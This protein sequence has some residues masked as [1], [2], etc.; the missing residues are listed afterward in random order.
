MLSRSLFACGRNDQNQYGISEVLNAIPPHQLL[1]D[2]DDLP[3]KIA[4][5]VSVRASD[6][7]SVVLTIHGDIYLCGRHTSHLGAYYSKPVTKWIRSEYM[8]SVVA[9]DCCASHSLFIIGTYDNNKAYSQQLQ[10]LGSNTYNEC[11]IE[12]SSALLQQMQKQQ[13]QQARQLA[14]QDYVKFPTTIQ[15]FNN[16]QVQ[17]VKCTPLGSFVRA[18]DEWYCF[19]NNKYGNLGAGTLL[20]VPVQ[21]VQELPQNVFKIATANSHTAA[22]TLDGKLFVA[23]SNANKQLGLLEAKN[24]STPVAGANTFTQVKLNFDV[25][26][27]ACGAS[28]TAVIAQQD[29]YRIYIAGKDPAAGFKAKEWAEFTRLETFTQPCK[30]VFAG[31]FTQFFVT[32]MLLFY[33][34]SLLWPLTADMSHYKKRIKS[35]LCLWSQ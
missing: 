19:G 11:G 7:F 13:Q 33:F 29:N 3:F 10:T 5:V 15:F 22:L 24:K 35:N 31:S 14:P 6:N 20:N 9:F 23:G 2:V 16:K 1:D 8:Y 18:D 17:Q 28:H 32:S 30:Q 12:L 25:V 34:F 4:D 21:L 27:V 26:D